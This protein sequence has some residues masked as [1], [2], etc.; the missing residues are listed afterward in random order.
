MSA[1]T[2]RRTVDAPAERVWAV[3]T[4]IGGWE[5]TISGINQVE[6]LSDG[7]FGTGTRWRET[8]TM[9]GREATEEMWVTAVDPGRSYTVEAESHGAHYVSTFT[10]T[11]TTPEQTEVALT[12]DAQPQ[13]TVAKVLAKVAAPVAQRSVAKALRQDLDD[14]AVA[15]ERA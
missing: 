12:F 3:A 10:F 13:G 1:V 5:R 6:L 15:A 2:T 8:R 11:A 7:D 9:F 14:I 4:D